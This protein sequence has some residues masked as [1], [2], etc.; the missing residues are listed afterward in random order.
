M[1]GSIGSENLTRSSFRTRRTPS[2]T[3][4]INL[5][6]NPNPF[7]DSL[8]SSQLSVVSSA[9]FSSLQTATAKCVEP[10]GGC[11]WAEWRGWC[12][13]RRYSGS[14][15]FIDGDLC[16]T[17]LDM[18]KMKQEEIVKSMNIEG[19]WDVGGKEVTSKYVEKGAIE[20]DDGRLSLTREL[21]EAEVEGILR[22][23]MC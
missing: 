7:R 15:R 9:F 1:N 13:E 11:P 17:F 21:V 2:P 22:A 12:S 4:A 8:R 16:E 5:I 20:D 18:D 10:V 3:T 23:V 19:G 14:K 6:H